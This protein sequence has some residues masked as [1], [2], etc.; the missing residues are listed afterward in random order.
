MDDAEAQKERKRLR[1]EKR[2]KKKA[3][4]AAAE[5]ADSAG[6][7]EK[8][9]DAGKEEPV[10]DLDWE[11]IKT[12]TSLN[13]L[14]QLDP[15]VDGVIG[16]LTDTSLFDDAGSENNEIHVTVKDLVA[17]VLAGKGSLFVT[18]KLAE[19]EGMNRRFSAISQVSEAL[20][21]VRAGRPDKMTFAKKTSKRT[22]EEL[23]QKDPFVD[24]VMQKLSNCRLFDHV[25][26]N[27]LNVSVDDLWNLI[28]AGKTGK[29]VVRILNMLE[30][31]S[32]RLSDF[33]S[34]VSKVRSLRKVARQEAKEERERE[35][36]ADE[37]ARKTEELKL[38]QLRKVLCGVCCADV[39]D[40]C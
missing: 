15:D 18:Q 29:L 20:G 11:A 12:A 32:A 39:S 21:N 22:L 30:K 31:Q 14:R 40:T 38:I 16:V 25:A 9:A 27:S 24:K 36:Q 34:L 33:D 37:A 13:K 28:A 23:K 3:E 6:V 7:E 1:K 26:N 4:A 8:G 19:W 5:V 2:R 17:I 35:R 10:P